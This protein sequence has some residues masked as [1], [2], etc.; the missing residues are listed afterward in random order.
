[1]KIFL[2]DERKTPSGYIGVKDP[3]VCIGLL[4]LN[5]GNVEILSLDHDLGIFV[6]GVELT[7]YDV[8]LWLEENTEYMPKWIG[9]HSANPV[10]RKRMH[11]CLD[12][13]ERRMAPA[14][15]ME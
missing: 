8:L 10:A 14:N 1:M 12:A 5:K 11:L 15:V 6:G 9:I 3:N 13:I 7:G 2:D 4:V